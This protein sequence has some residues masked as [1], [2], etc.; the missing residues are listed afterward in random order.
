MENDKYIWHLQFDDFSASVNARSGELVSFYSHSASER[1]DGRTGRVTRE[2]AERTAESFIRRAAGN[3]FNNVELQ[4]QSN[5]WGSSDDRYGFFYTR[6]VNGVPFPNNYIS[7]TVDSTSGRIIHYDTSWFDNV[8]F[9]DLR[10]ANSADDAFGVFAGEK[11]FDLFYI[12]VENNK[13]A[14]VYGFID[15]PGYT[16]DPFNGEKLGHD[17]KPFRLQEGVTQYD[18]IS[19]RWYEETV[20]ALLDNGYFIP[21]TSFNGN[22]EITQEEFLRFMHSPWQSHMNQ[23]DFY[24]MLINNNIIMDGEKSPESVISRQDAVKFAIR[25]LGLDKAAKDGSIFRNTYNDAISQEY[26]GYAAIA[27]ALEI[28]R[29]DSRGN[30]NGGRNMTRAEAAV[31]LLNTLRNR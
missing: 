22:N 12:K 11:D 8:V 7:V 26:L 16:V 19:G 31:V 23:N 20:M 29:G 6:T 27:R 14:L 30:F 25:F 2:A 9:P 13:F 24:D 10:N 1:R 4:E 21:G 28:T 3:K 15:F 18:D 17:G 5:M